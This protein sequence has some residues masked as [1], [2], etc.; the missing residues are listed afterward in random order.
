MFSGNLAGTLS[1]LRNLANEEYKQFKRNT[2]LDMDDA[3]AASNVLCGVC[4]S[5]SSGSSSNGCVGG[6]GNLCACICDKNATRDTGM[7]SLLK[8]FQ[9]AM[10][11]ADAAQQ[12][13]SEGVGARMVMANFRR[14]LWYWNEYY[15]RRGRD[16][17]SIEFSCH[18][19][20]SYWSALVGKC[21]VS[22]CVFFPLY[23]LL[24]AC[25]PPLYG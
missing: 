2:T 12:H 19:P 13:C 25:R 6:G 8:N 14:L 3:D 23:T 10:S 4:Q 16:R 15:L 20:F 22:V 1:A 5:P 17:L 21:W 7:N 24:N 9:R 18:I 11:V